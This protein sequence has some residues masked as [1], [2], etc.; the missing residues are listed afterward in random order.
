MDDPRAD[1]RPPPVP[2]R[3]L[4]LGPS[5]AGQRLDLFLVA[6]LSLSRGQVRRLLDRGAVSLDGR[7][8][9]L[10][11]KGLRL[12]E[13]G[14]L[15]VEA[16]RSGTDARARPPEPGAQ[17]PVIV[18]SGP[19][20]LA[21]DKPAGMPVHP[22]GEE[23]IG[24][25]LGHLLAVH[26]EIHGIGEG[27]LRSG[28]VHRLDVD[29]SGVM[30][31]ATD[32]KSWGRLRGAFQAHRVR[33][34][35]RALVQGD[36]DPPGGVL[37]MAL[38]LVVARHRPAHVR[39]ATPAEVERGRAREVVQRVLRLAKLE[40]A[41]LIE[42]HPR[43]GFLHQIRATLAHLGHPLVGDRRYDATDDK[44]GARRHML[45]AAEIELEEIHALAG[46]PLDFRACLRALGGEEGIL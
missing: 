16:F 5:A 28:V 32:A 17:A 41:T 45:H 46:E 36:L 3:I 34:V 27:G 22:L 40:G 11:D 7:S 25:L 39:V 15:A 9:G 23:E 24:T 44:S 38:P 12:P 10:R 31:V 42:V 14:A 19:G 43:T 8:L 35:Y 1:G 13:S 6:E 2:A 26:P 29:T 18:A 30:L 4:A 20:W 21:V 37:D 33:K